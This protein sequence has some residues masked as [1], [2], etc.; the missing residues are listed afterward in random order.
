MSESTYEAAINNALEVLNE[1]VEEAEAAGLTVVV[2]QREVKMG[3]VKDVVVNSFEVYQ[4]L[5]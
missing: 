4:R 3:K 5:M 2:R 1:V